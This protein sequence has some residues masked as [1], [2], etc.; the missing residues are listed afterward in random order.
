[1]RLTRR[2]L[3]HGAAHNF[4]Q[5]GHRQTAIE[6]AIAG[7]AKIYEA[8]LRP[9]GDNPVYSEMEETMREWVVEALLQGAYLRECHLWEKDCKAYFAIMAER[10]DETIVINTK[11]SQAFT[12]LIEDTLVRVDVAMPLDILGTIESARRRVNT[13]KQDAGLELDHFITEHHYNEAVKIDAG[14]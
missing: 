8:N 6:Y 1:M 9:F 5:V 11:G 12:D 3:E 7:I 13:M 14:Q 10:N 2:Y 4:I